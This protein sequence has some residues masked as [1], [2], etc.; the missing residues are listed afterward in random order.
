MSKAEAL[1]FLQLSLGLPW[2]HFYL[3]LLAKRVPS[4]PSSKDRDTHTP[5]C[6]AAEDECG[7][8]VA[9]IFE[10]TNCHRLNS[11]VAEVAIGSQF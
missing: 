8:I 5:G 4:P 7:G 1:P 11:I 3:T 2:P 6:Q 9:T 10:V